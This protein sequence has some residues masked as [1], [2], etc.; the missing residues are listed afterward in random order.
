[1]RKL[2]IFNRNDIVL[3]WRIGRGYSLRIR[4]FLID[5]D[6]IMVPR[7][8]DR[9]DIN[10]YSKKLAE[11]ADTLFVVYHME[12]VASCSVYCNSEVAYISSI[13]VKKEFQ[14]CGIGY[15]MMSEIKKHVK[16][17]KISSIR[18]HV[19]KKND[20]AISLYKK[21]SFKI[22]DQENDWIELETLA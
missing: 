19:H 17:K 11:N 9:V 7:L 18:L 8:S 1:M 13:A 14:N 2:E 12:D 20:K 15:L 3:E 10:D 22:I 16:E 4:D 6:S 5:I 21:N